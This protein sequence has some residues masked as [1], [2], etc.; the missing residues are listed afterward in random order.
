[1]LK[2]KIKIL[3]KQGKTYNEIAKEL[4]CSKSTVCY[5]LDDG[6]IVC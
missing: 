3:R 4:D 6:H 1:M 5:H 2:N